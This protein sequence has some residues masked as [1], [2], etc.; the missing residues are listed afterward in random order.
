M[1]SHVYNRFIDQDLFFNEDAFRRVCGTLQQ[2]ETDNLRH[3]LASEYKLS[4]DVLTKRPEGV[5]GQTVGDDNFRRDARSTNNNNN[6]GSF[7]DLYFGHKPF[8]L[9][10]NICIANSTTIG[11][12][13]RNILLDVKQARL[14]FGG[15]TTTTTTTSQ[16]PIRRTAS[17]SSSDRVF[18]RID[19]TPL[20]VL[21]FIERS[22]NGSSRASPFAPR[23]NLDK[24]LINVLLIGKQGIEDVANAHDRPPTTALRHLEEHDSTGRTAKVERIMDVLVQARPSSVR[25]LHAD[26]VSRFGDE[27]VTAQAEGIQ[28]V[29]DVINEMVSPSPSADFLSQLS[30]AQAN[31]E[32]KR[33][34]AE[35]AQRKYEQTRT[36]KDGLTAQIAQLR[37]EQANLIAARLRDKEA[38]FHAE[39]SELLRNID[40]LKEEAARLRQVQQMQNM[41]V[42]HIT[43]SNGLQPSQPI[44]NLA[45]VRL[46]NNE[47]QLRTFMRSLPLLTSVPTVTSSVTLEERTG[48]PSRVK[49]SQI[50]QNLQQTYA[51]PCPPAGMV[52]QAVEEKV[53]TEDEKL[54][55]PIIEDPCGSKEAFYKGESTVCFDKYQKFRN[56]LMSRNIETE[57]M[58]TSMNELKMLYDK[59]VSRLKLLNA[60][61]AQGNPGFKI[62]KAA[63]TIEKQKVQIFTK[64]LADSEFS[65]TILT[66]LEPLFAV[67]K[68]ICKHFVTL[69]LGLDVSRSGRSTSEVICQSIRNDIFYGFLESA[70]S[71]RH[72]IQVRDYLNYMSTDA[73]IKSPMKT[74]VTVQELDKKSGETRHVTMEVQN[75]LHTMFSNLGNK[76]LFDRTTSGNLFTRFVL[77]MAVREAT[78]V[79]GFQHTGFVGRESNK[80]LKETYIKGLTELVVYLINTFYMDPVKRRQIEQLKELDF[81]YEIVNI[82]ET[83]EATLETIT[84]VNT[85]FLKKLGYLDTIYSNDENNKAFIY[86]N[87]EEC[88]EIGDEAPLPKID[89]Y[90]TNPD[91]YPVGKIFDIDGKRNIV[92]KRGQKGYENKYNPIIGSIPFDPS[93]FK[94][95]N[96]KPRTSIEEDQQVFTFNQATKTFTD[97]LVL[98]KNADGS[99]IVRTFSMLKITV[100]APQLTSEEKV[101]QAKSILS[102]VFGQPNL[103]DKTTL[104]EL[105]NRTS[106]PA[107]YP[108][109]THGVS[110]H[111]V[112][113]LPPAQAGIRVDMPTFDNVSNVTLFN[114]RRFLELAF[115]RMNNVQKFTFKRLSQGPHLTPINTLNRTDYQKKIAE[116]IFSI[117]IINQPNSFPDQHEE[118]QSNDK[119]TMDGLIVFI[120]DRGKYKLTSKSGK[121]EDVPTEYIKLKCDPTS[122]VVEFFRPPSIDHRKYPVELFLTE[123]ANCGQDV[124]QHTPTD[125]NPFLKTIQVYVT[126]E[127]PPEVQSTGGG[128]VT[129]SEEVKVSVRDRL[130]R[131]QRQNS[132][133]GRSQH[134]GRRSQLEKP[135]KLQP[136]TSRRVSKANVTTNKRVR[137]R[138]TK[139]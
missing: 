138:P 52:E 110:L 6:F 20:G 100:Y 11:K 48:Q 15:T 103:A 39:K 59:A 57:Q 9:F 86:L 41:L 137:A 61:M 60:K 127:I 92:L 115:E 133:Y 99:V 120:K 68:F 33:L 49:L 69:T 23:G 65:S 26:N 67:A 123:T 78:K 58:P 29:L 122:P 79:S 8:R 130:N 53:L 19:Y 118:F 107:C 82:E 134:R 131:L 66:S 24:Q 35:E 25:V 10:T 116:R 13:W 108:E 93:L 16:S 136:R 119:L 109:F 70:G 32:T 94:L 74:S 105:L 139:R 81:N 124:V 63:D 47:V 50:I 95:K 37:A 28:S 88:L 135:K 17:T 51:L 75:E 18:D 2:P 5:I 30:T 132:H 96:E 22:T 46:H 72:L 106:V 73:F 34:E 55:V 71:L 38:T 98:K 1:L 62:E 126:Y 87:V 113:T 76:L 114:N 40:L 84:D 77:W 36:E 111:F 90:K 4:F 7:R 129:A 83:Q 45:T 54:L 121:V 3:F 91:E 64:M 117:H 89:K 27:L 128:S 104:V 101:A 43:T 21:D 85:L 102:I 125:K 42:P 44:E 80:E 56:E 12:K 97:V 14:R 112:D 31:A